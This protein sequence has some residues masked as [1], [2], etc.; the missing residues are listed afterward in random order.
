[1][2]SYTCP[3]LQGIWGVFVGAR[4]GPRN[5]EAG[6]A[7]LL[8]AISDSQRLMGA[9]FIAGFVLGGYTGAW[10]ARKLQ[11]WKSK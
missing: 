2:S 11:K 8:L 7:M 1:M 10:W 5:G 6:P 4:Q 3:S 9:V